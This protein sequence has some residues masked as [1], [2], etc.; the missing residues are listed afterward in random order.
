MVT[1][2]QPRRGSDEIALSV[3]GLTVDYHTAD[4]DLR[5]VND[6]SLDLHEG[7]TLGVIGESGSGKST[8]GTAMAGLLTGGPGRRVRGRIQLS[9]S[10]AAGYRAVGD[11]LTLPER[12]LRRIRGSALAMVFQDAMLSLNPVIRVGTQLDEAIRL[13]QPAMTRRE[14]RRRVLDLLAQVGIDGPERCCTAYPHQLSGGMRQRVLIAMAVAN[15]PRVLIAD[16]P[17]TA[18]DV[19]VQAQVLEVLRATQRRTGCA[20]VLISH[21]LG[22]IA[23]ISDEILVMYAGAAVERSGMADFFHAPAHPYSAGLLRSM[24][25]LDQ[26]HRSGLAIPGSPPSMT[27]LPPGCSFAPRCRYAGDACTRD[28]PVLAQIGTGGQLAAC[29]HPLSGPETVDVAPAPASADAAPAPTGSGGVGLAVHGLVKSFVT[30]RALRPAARQVVRAVDDV[31]LVLP[32]GRTLAL[33]GESGSGKTTV[34]RCIMRL[35]RPERGRVELPGGAGAAQAQMVFQDP[36]S[37]LDPL[38]TV[39]DSIAEPLRSHGWRSGPTA[40]RVDQL[41]AMVGLESR[42][43]NRY[44][45]ELSGGQRQ[46]VSIARALALHPTLL[47]LDEPTA[48]LDTSIQAQIVDLLLRLQAELGLSYLLISHDMALVRQLAH[49]VAVMYGGRIVESGP[50]EAVLT[51]PAEQYTRSLLAAVPTIPGPGTATPGAPR[52]GS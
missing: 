44:P 21:N 11:L 19:T 38:W 3:A 22:V 36:S 40:Q 50:C 15:E 42:H 24:P 29:F 34:A 27:Q 33:V 49:T 28:R 30:R 9:G 48:A 8:L 31:N 14:R 17:T 18:L 16:E 37:S 20:L 51:A 52:D 46:R 41:L 45:R 7:Q 5:A 6:V 43:G 23:Q 26:P 32:A 12:A 1:A 13:H 47:V 35:T 25:R 10:P 39:R 2:S 4:G